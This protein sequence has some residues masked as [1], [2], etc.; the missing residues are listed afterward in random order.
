MEK[1]YIAVLVIRSTIKGH[2]N[3][4]PMTELQYR[5]ITA[6]TDEDAYHRAI[7]LGTTENHS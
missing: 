5:L 7:E 3:D 4:V 1:W 2:E 6:K